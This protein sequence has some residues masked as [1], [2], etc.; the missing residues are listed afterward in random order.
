MIQDIHPG[1]GS[2]LGIFIFTHPGSR[3]QGSKRHRILDPQSSPCELTTRSSTPILILIRTT[4]KAYTVIRFVWVSAKIGICTVVSVNGTLVENKIGRFQGEC[5]HF[6]FN[7]CP[8]YIN[9]GA[10]AKF[11]INSHETDNSVH[12]PLPG[13]WSWSWQWL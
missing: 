1:S 8:T 12:Q 13:L 5:A 11:S 3:I 10:S 6:I 7:K 9:D 2:R 4:M